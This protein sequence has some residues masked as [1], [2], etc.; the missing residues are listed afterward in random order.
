MKETEDTKLE[1]GTEV[2]VDQKTSTD[3]VLQEL[4]YLKGKVEAQEKQTTFL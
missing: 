2:H 1:P 4:G 3:N